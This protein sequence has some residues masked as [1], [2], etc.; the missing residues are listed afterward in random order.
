MSGQTC[1]VSNP[2]DRTITQIN[3]DGTWTFIIPRPLEGGTI[4][5]G[6]K[7]PNNWDDTPSPETRERLLAMAAKMYPPIL[8]SKGKFDVITDIVGRRPARE[9]GLRL[10]SET[11]E[12]DLK[13]KRIIHAYG[14]EGSG[15]ALSWGIAEEVVK[16]A[17]E[18][19]VTVIR[20]P[21]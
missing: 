2:C 4:I 12:G 19:E 7:E 18:S 6:T 8:W 5:G 15:Y 17:L 20:S 1:L 10:E 11:M 14:A 9:G 21:M 16:M 13:G 3:P